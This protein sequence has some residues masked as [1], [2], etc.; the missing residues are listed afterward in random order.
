MRIR[1]ILLSAILILPLRMTADV[2]T[3]TYTEATSL[4]LPRHS[5]LAITL[6]D[7]LQQLL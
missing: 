7:L 1:T 4:L 6:P 3:Y 2:T 5:P